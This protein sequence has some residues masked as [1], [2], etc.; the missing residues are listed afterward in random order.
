M[1]SVG[2]AFP[3][4]PLFKVQHC[5]LAKGYVFCEKVVEIIRYE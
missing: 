2:E 3:E 4:L 1:G 5:V